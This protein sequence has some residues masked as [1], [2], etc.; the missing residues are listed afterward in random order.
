[1]TRFLFLFFFSVS[2]AM[3]ED[4]CITKTEQVIENGNVVKEIIYKSCTETE[5]LNKSKFFITWLTDERYQNSVVM[6]FMGI[7]ENL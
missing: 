3:A 6:V 7:L 2:V 1:M 4:N 5:N